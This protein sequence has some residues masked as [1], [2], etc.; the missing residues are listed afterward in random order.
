VFKERRNI[1]T[2]REAW[3]KAR[4]AGGRAGC[5]DREPRSGEGG[6][7]GVAPRAFEV[8]TLGPG[9]R[10]IQDQGFCSGLLCSKIAF[11]FMD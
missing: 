6:V 3:P 10:S 7:G 8:I 2:L 1:S 5:R 4:I 11:D 9:W